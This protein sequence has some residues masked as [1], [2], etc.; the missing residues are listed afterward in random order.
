MA[1]VSGLVYQDNLLTAATNQPQ[2][3]GARS[4]EAGLRANMD[5]GFV[6]PTVSSKAASKYSSASVT[7]LKPLS[8][9]E[10]NAGSSASGEGTTTGIATFARQIQRVLEDDGLLYQYIGEENSPFYE[11]TH[12]LEEYIQ[13]KGLIA[14]V[15]SNHK[16][17]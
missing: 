10:M 11:Y 7:S 16:P 2:F 17:N 15:P 6:A 5:N 1:R 9:K 3:N 12:L 8:S 14:L 13:F 4:N